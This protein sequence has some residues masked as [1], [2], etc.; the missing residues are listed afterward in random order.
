MV[1]LSHLY[2]TT[3]KKRSFDYM[4]LCLQSDICFNTL[5]RFVITFLSRSKCFLISWLQLPS[6][7]ILEPTKIKSI[8]VSIVS[9]TICHE[10]MELDALILFFWMS[11]FKPTFLHCRL[12]LSSRG[13]VVLL[14]FLPWGRCH[15]Q[16][17]GYW[18][19]SQQSWFQLV[20]H[21]TWHFSGCTLHIS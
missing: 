4:D 12:S 16:L 10:M 2:T 5:S 7:V 11:R 18:Y 17:W 19:F 14:C 3:G 6:A 13:S 8:T 20:F 15:L 21:P 9:P 1:Q